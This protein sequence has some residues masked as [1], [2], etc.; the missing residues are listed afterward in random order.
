MSAARWFGL[1]EEHAPGLGCALNCA[2]PAQFAQSLS[3][4]LA[5]RR[6]TTLATCGQTGNDVLVGRH[7][8]N[9]T[10]DT[11]YG[12]GG[13]TTFHNNNILLGTA[14]AR[15]NDNKIVVLASS[16]LSS[17]L[18]DHWLII[19]FN[20]NGSLDT[21]FGTAVTCG[22]MFQA[23]GTF[24]PAISPSTASRARSPSAFRRMV[25]SSWRAIGRAELWTPASVGSE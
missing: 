7:N 20:A 19:R 14:C 13:V 21:T 23:P 8:A 24:I 12:W 25:T 10:V 2:E 5:Q 4:T 3:A 17:N 15:T 6:A 11:S 16:G 22:T 18:D 9:G 1:R